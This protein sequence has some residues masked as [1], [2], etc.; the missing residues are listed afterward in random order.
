VV[1]PRPAD[2]TAAVRRLRA[3]PGG[4]EELSRRARE[5]SRRTLDAELEDLARRL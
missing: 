2:V 5:F 4:R 3:D 1:C